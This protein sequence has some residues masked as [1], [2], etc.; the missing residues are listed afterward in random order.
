[1]GAHTADG[2]AEKLKSAAHSYLASGI[3]ANFVGRDGIV[4][5]ESKA[6][7]VKAAIEA[8]LPQTRNRNQSAENAKSAADK[9][10]A[11]VEKKIAA[12]RSRDRAT[13]PIMP[14]PRKTMREN[15]RQLYL[16][17][18]P[19]PQSSQQAGASPA[20]AVAIGS[21]SAGALVG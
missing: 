13:P 12:A 1:M 20:T 4:T 6:S 17:S 2:A 5:D 21:G 9:A 16:D 15:T 10:E 19:G 14:I 3:E 8:E 18:A 11:G 7:A